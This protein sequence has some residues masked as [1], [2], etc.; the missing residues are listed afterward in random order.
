[1]GPYT[2][3]AHFDKANIIFSPLCWNDHRKK[4]ESMANQKD[5]GWLTN[6]WLNDS[7]SNV[8]L[9]WAVNWQNAAE[10]KIGEFLQI[11]LFFFL[12]FLRRNRKTPNSQLLSEF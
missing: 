5:V 11:L 4:R 9:C 10:L 6:N 1:M 8:Q 2:P 3:G 12:V 7:F